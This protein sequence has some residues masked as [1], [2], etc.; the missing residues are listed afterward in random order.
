[1][2]QN[3]DLAR[4]YALTLPVPLL[5]A[6]A[7]EV[8][9]ALAADAMTDLDQGVRKIRLASFREPAHRQHADSDSLTR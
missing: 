4:T 1:M 9:F 7:E 2:R 6:F 3:P 5:K 8:A